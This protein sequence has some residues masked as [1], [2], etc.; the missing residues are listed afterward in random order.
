[1]ACVPAAKKPLIP[2]SQEKARFALPA[3][4]KVEFGSDSR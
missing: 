4:S 2:L 1:M 3:G